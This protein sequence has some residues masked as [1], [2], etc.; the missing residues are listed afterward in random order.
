MARGERRSSGRHHRPSY[1]GRTT[2]VL[3]AKADAFLKA[4]EAKKTAKYKEACAL[5][6][7]TFAPAVF[8]SWGGQGPSTKDVLF[9]LVRRAVG[10]APPE[11]RAARIAEQ[12]QMLSISLMRQVWKLLSAKNSFQ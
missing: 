5:E 11:L 4:V 6:G 9:R 10:G 3:P 12:R 8:D 1:T 7:W 2:T